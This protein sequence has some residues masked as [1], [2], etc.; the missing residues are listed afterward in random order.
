MLASVRPCISSMAVTNSVRALHDRSSVPRVVDDREKARWKVHDVGYK[1]RYHQRGV[2]ALPRIPD[3]RVPVDR[4]EYKERDAWR[5]SQARFGQNDYIDLLGDGSLHP[6]QL[7]YHVPNWLRGFPGQHRANELIKLIHYRN[8][9]KEKLQNNSPRRWHE[10]QKR[11]KFLLMYHNY[12]KQDEIKD[13]R[14][15]GL[16]DEKPD[17]FY[18]DKSRRSYTDLI[19]R[20]MDSMFDSCVNFEPPF[21][22]L[23]NYALVSADGKVALLGKQFEAA[24]DLSKICDYVTSRLWFTYRRGFQPIGGTGPS[25]DQGWGCM[26]RCAQMLLGEVLLRRHIGEHYHWKREKPS[27][28]Y[29]KILN[30]FLDE[31]AA[32][33]SIHQIAQMGVSEGKQVGEWFG[34]NTAAQVLKKL[35][36]FD[37]WSGLAVHVALDNILIRDDVRT[38]ATTNPPKD[39]VKLIVEDG[40]LGD[41]FL[42][43]SWSAEFEETLNQDMTWRP[44]LLVIPLRLGLTGINRCYLPAIKKYFELPQC[45]GIMGGR[46]NHALFFVGITGDK[47]IYLDPHICQLSLSA[48]PGQ[49][50]SEAY[51]DGF[52]AVETTEA[53]D[54][55]SLDDSTYH[56]PNP[57]AMPY[58]QVDPSLALTFFCKT[59]ADFEALSRELDEEL[60]PSTKPSLFEQLQSR[61]SYW[62]PFEPYLGVRGN[63]EM[64]EF[65]DMGDPNF[66]SDEEFEV[67]Q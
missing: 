18:K 37:Q 35:C 34:P 59:E 9:Y 47:L 61:P 26:L 54:E 62:P 41:H 5:E 29:E 21:Q 65:H 52:E 24:S 38:I 22:E 42:N 60:L 13:E 66:D 43:R 12:N 36:V 31:K 27:G 44:L 10:L 67:L 11:I 48:Q 46:P 20:L 33:Y 57:L 8:L 58:D 39:A 16:W 3:C 23:Q 7:Q 2:E 51:F 32:L 50:R 30:M 4:P 64:K 14:D 40:R 53:S 56:C 19:A 63:V 49:G 28:D 6:A 45:T 25:S 15:L 17:Y 55:K 1:F